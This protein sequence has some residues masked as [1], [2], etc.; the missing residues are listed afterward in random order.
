MNNLICNCVFFP[1]R[2]LF[3][4]FALVIL[5]TLLT[6]Q[7]TIPEPTEFLVNDYAGLLG[8]SEVIALGR[9][10]RDYVGETSTQIVVVTERS[11]EGDDPFAY[12]QRLASA[13]GI[14]G[15][16][17][18]NGILIFVAQQERQVRIQTGRGTEGFLPDVTAKRIIENIIVPQFRSGNYYQGLDRA[19]DAIMDLGRGE[20]EG[21]DLSGNGS[22]QIPDWV[23]ILFIILL[24]IILSR[25]S[26]HNDDDD[27][28][29]YR[30][31]RYD[32]PTRR[33]R[34]GRTVIFPGGGWSRGGGGG[35]GGGMDG[36]GGFGGGGF[37]GFGGGS[38]GG[39]GAGGSW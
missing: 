26:N 29:Y 1:W 32:M 11:L 15:G 25:M 30:G 23:I 10:L 9:K 14:G 22:N 28:G 8:R 2:L 31:G 5:P 12:A 4:G 24:I 7:K 18:D 38:F 36:F 37:G 35:G 39:G 17:N 16:A 21:D 13:W 3:L 20:Y 27:G 19:T 6:A 34:R 33:N